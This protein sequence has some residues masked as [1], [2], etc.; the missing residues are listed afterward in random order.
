[1]RRPAVALAAVA[2][3]VA[4]AC[5]DTDDREAQSFQPSIAWGEC[6]T[7]IEVTFT[8]RHECGVLTVLIDH[9][10][11]SKGTLELTV[12]RAW[13]QDGGDRDRY[14]FTYGS[15]IGN[16]DAILGGMTANA[17]SLDIVGVKLE[18]RGTGPQG[19]ALPAVSRDRRGRA[20]ARRCAD[21]RRG[22]GGGLPRRR[23]QLSRPASGP[24][25]RPGR[26]RRRPRRSRTPTTPFA[27]RSASTDRAVTSSYG[28]QSRYLFEAM[29]E[30]PETLGTTY[31]NSPWPAGTNELTGDVSLTRAKLDEL[32]RACDGNPRCRGPQPLADD[33]RSA[34]ERLSEHP[35][36]DTFHGRV[37]G[38]VDVLVDGPKLVR[39]AR[40][41]LGGDGPGQPDAAS[42]GDPSGGRRAPRSGPGPDRRRRPG[43]VLRV[44]RHLLGTGRRRLGRVPHPAVPPRPAVPRPGPS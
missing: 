20:G 36:T 37:G 30:H 13:P 35:L 4:T 11:P 29:R 18:W 22:W 19:R 25:R 3:L 39:A 6:P 23:R 21:G 16:H 41:A 17:A 31:V 24:G 32:F 9:A 7:D 8:A 33:W 42:P 27:G 1:M 5:D 26:L 34:L 12:G 40:F 2:L 43:H 15:D 44:P 38:P 10:D 28:T 14:G